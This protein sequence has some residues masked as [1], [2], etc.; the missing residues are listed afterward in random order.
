MDRCQSRYDQTQRF[1]DL[2]MLGKL[3]Q[4]CGGAVVRAAVANAA[5]K[6]IDN[7]TCAACDQ[8]KWSIVY[9]WLQRLTRS[10]PIQ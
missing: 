10:A 4:A 7:S 5:Q 2:Q 1:G 3:L 9:S 8:I 6:V